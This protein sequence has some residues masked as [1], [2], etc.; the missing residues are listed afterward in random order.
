MKQ[1]K[2][3]QVETQEIIKNL[4]NTDKNKLWDEAINMT[5]HT[6]LQP[7]DVWIRV[8]GD[9]FVKKTKVLELDTDKQCI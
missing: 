6:S 5:R 8:I 3:L 4:S 1:D 7:I 9:F 2:V